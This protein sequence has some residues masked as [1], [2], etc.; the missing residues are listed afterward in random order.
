MGRSSLKEIDR[1]WIYLMVV[2]ALAIPLISGYSVEPA[3]M[4]SA[5][6]L[7]HV[8]SDLEVPD[9]DIAFIALDWGP[10]TRPENGPQT[11]M[12]IEH[13]MRRRIKFALFS[14]YVFA[15]PFLVSIPETIAQRLMQEQPGEAWEYGV[16]W[17]NLG[18]K[19]AARYVIQGIPK[20]DN[21]IDLFV[22]D[23]FGTSLSQVP[24]FSKVRTIDDI[25][26]LAQFTGLVG[27]VDLYVQFFQSETYRPKF[28]HGCTSITIPEAYIYLDSGQ[29]VGLLEG[30]AG[31]A[32]YSILL[33]REF[34]LRAVDNTLSL[35]TGLGVAHLVILFL[36]VAGNLAFI[37]GRR[38][39][40]R[41]VA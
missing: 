29:I 2:L 18:Y 24:A 8:I 5:E 3:R 35:N 33:S 9:G 17:V 15:E 16:D 6:K 12:V 20:A 25:R 36:I 19:P 28:G 38:S 34:P 32:W 41:R 31:A 11:E 37:W 40:E 7:Y 21:L 14:T 4:R 1:R 30:I 10:N 13:L 26:F 27:T 39:S 22:Q 23:A